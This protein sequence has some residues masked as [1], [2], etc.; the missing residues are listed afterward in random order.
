MALFPFFDTPK[1]AENNNSGE[2]DAANFRIMQ[3][4][5]KTG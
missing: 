1:K 3:L 2:I 5:K 4:E